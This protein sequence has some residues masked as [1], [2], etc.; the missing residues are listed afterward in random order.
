MIGI[1]LCELAYMAGSPTIFGHGNWKNSTQTFLSENMLRRHCWLTVFSCYTCESMV[2]LCHS[3]LAMFSL[4]CS[5]SITS[6][7]FSNP[8]IPAWWGIPLMSRGL[9]NGLTETLSQLYYS[10]RFFSTQFFHPFL[11]L[12]VSISA[13]SFF[14]FHR[15]FLHKI[16]ILALWL[17]R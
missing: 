7:G 10:L 6:W 15:H 9:L 17:F 2:S 16:S 3:H 12:W 1:T 8:V 4:G 11:L 14:I 5:Q 13:C